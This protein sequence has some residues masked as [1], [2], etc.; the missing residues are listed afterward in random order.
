MA[1]IHS[2]TKNSDRKYLYESYPR[3]D[4]L[5]RNT[6]ESGTVEYL[7]ADSEAKSVWS[8]SKGVFEKIE[9]F[10]TREPTIELN[11]EPAREP[12]PLE[13]LAP[14]KT[15]S[16]DFALQLIALV[17]NKEPLKDVR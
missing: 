12:A 15:V 1:T 11:T 10:M 16:E 17:A 4:I 6:D 8:L 5:Y 2:K 14:S 7:I 3:K 13:E 9:K